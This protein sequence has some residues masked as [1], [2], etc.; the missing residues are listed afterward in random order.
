MNQR[1]MNICHIDK[2]W[3]THCTNIFL[4]VR[5][6]ITEIHKLQNDLDSIDS[7]S[8]LFDIGAKYTRVSKSGI[9]SYF[10]T[11]VRLFITL[12]A[13]IIITCYVFSTDA[14]NE[15]TPLD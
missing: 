14:D 5:K 1:T 10:F 12:A 9:C 2:D 8:A 13:F 7:N 3:I 15:Q 11:M 4:L 6:I